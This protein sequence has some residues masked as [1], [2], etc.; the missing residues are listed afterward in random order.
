MTSLSG[1]RI[2]IVEDEIFI[3]LMLETM[4]VELGCIVARAVTN[5]ANALSLI[6]DHAECL[7]AATVDINLGG[8][9]GLS[10]AIA[11]R[12]QGIPFV[13]TTGYDDPA[14]LVGWEEWPRIEKPFTREDLE[15]AL[16]T[17]D[18]KHEL[19]LRSPP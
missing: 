12:A 10:V 14:I 2:L 17:L 6:E 9:S 3:A 15:G 8:E 19:G 11:L 16:A 18:W 5:R 7:D 4:L 1:R 13:V